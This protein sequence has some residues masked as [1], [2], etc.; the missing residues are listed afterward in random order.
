VHFE[1]NTTFRRFFGT[2]FPV[3]TSEWTELLKQVH[4]NCLMLH[5]D[6]YRLNGRRRFSF[7]KINFVAVCSVLVIE[8]LFKTPKNNY[9]DLRKSE[10]YVS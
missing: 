6:D 8:T 3:K 4:R 7:D 9:C 5:C 1:V 10:L 2:K